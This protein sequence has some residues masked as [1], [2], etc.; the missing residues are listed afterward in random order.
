V[1]PFED[2]REAADFAMQLLIGQR[3]FVAWFA[4]PHYCSLFPTRPFDMPVMFRRI[5]SVGDS[6]IVSSAAS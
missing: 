2:I 1:F 3:A 5:I 4:F 6:I